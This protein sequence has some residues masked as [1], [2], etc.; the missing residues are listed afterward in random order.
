MFLGIENILEDDLV[1]LKASAKNEF[2]EAG[3]K[4]GNATLRAIDYLHKNKMYVVG[5][6][7][8][9]N[10]DDTRE[11][12]QDQPGVRPQVRRLALYPASHAVSRHADD[13][14]LPAPAI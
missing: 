14:G 13:E 7:I 1:F 12:I 5:G 3:R 4:T 10:P 11:S 2:R 6:L 8:V 9:G